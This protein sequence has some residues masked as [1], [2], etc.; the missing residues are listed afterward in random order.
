MINILRKYI[1]GFWIWWYIIENRNVWRRIS[2]VF[3]FT[4]GYFNVV[5]MVQNLFVPLFQDETRTGRLISFP[6]RLAWI[7][8]GSLLQ[9][10]VLIPLLAIYLTYLVLPVLPFWG[11]V[12]YLSNL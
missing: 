4:L 1:F 3:N 9:I 2:G 11:I 8:I 7:L 6:I 12:S 10:F 5:P